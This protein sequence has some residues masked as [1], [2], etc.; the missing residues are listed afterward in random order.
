MRTLESINSEIANI[1]SESANTQT[2]GRADKNA[3]RERVSFLRHCKLYLESSPNPE[4]VQSEFDRMEK[5]STY[6]NDNLPEFVKSY[7]N[8]GIT[9]DEKKNE[10]YAKMNRTNVLRQIRTLKFIL[11]K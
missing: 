4:F 2:M 5:L 3:L 8:D 9:F 6:I 10:W 1:I 11:N 7:G